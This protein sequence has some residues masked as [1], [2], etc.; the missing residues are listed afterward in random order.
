MVGL[1]NQISLVAR[2]KRSGIREECPGFRRCAAASG[3][4]HFVNFFMFDSFQIRSG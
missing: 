3:L 4:R 1:R 2:M